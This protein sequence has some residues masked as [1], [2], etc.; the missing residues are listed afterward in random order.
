MLFLL[1]ILFLFLLLVSVSSDGSKNTSRLQYAGHRG[2]DSTGRHQFDT[3][4][5][6]TGGFSGGAQ[7]WSIRQG[8]HHS[9]DK[10]T[11]RSGGY[12][13][14][15]VGGGIK[16]RNSVA[17]DRIPE[18]GWHQHPPRGP[19]GFDKIKPRAPSG[20]AV[21]RVVERSPRPGGSDYESCYL[22]K[23]EGKGWLYFLPGMEVLYW[24]IGGM[25]IAF[26]IQVHAMVRK[27]LRDEVTALEKECI[28]LQRDCKKL[29]LEIDI[30]K[31][32]DVKTQLKRMAQFVSLQ[33]IHRAST[34]LLAREQ[35]EQHA[36]ALA[37]RAKLRKAN[38]TP[39]APQPAPLENA[40]VKNL[41]SALKKVSADLPPEVQ[42][43]MQKMHGD[44]DKQLT[45]Q[46]HSAVSQ[47]GNSKKALA[48]LS[49]ARSN[50]HSSWN[51]FLE[52]AITRWVRYSEEFTQQDKD[53]AAQ[54]EK[55]K[56]TM[57]ACKE[58]FKSLQALEGPP[59]SAPAE[60]ISDEEDSALPSKVDVH[61]QQMQ[62]S[63]KLLKGEMEEELRG[64]KRQR[65]EEEGPG[66]TGEAGST[67]SLCGQGGK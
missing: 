12:R 21:Q 45:K 13:G 23:K 39:S 40:Q 10:E 19:S 66:T 26:L 55:A 64:A 52:S 2:G 22:K 14:Q 48:D 24:G 51:T 54:I 46:L 6:A 5:M 9:L 62:D 67:A 31:E 34:R 29:Q 15:A 1:N 53:L 32:A 37:E 58:H 27:E 38:K 28:R 42:A 65:V 63:L 57:K 35:E 25:A 16:A 3:R 20:D 8:G 56:E 60:V 61:M 18:R 11:H 17:E 30:L 44:D 7:N 43:A 4:A 33:E 50:L 59:S 47:L 41:L 36:K 49:A